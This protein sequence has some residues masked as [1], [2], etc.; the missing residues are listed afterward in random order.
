[1]KVHF[2]AAHFVVVGRSIS[3]LDSLTQIEA[4]STFFVPRAAHNSTTFA[5]GNFV[6]KVSNQQYNNNVNCTS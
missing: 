2:V 3:L 1:M 4:S 5:F 6:K